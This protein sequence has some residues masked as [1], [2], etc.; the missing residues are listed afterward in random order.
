MAGGVGSMD[1]AATPKLAPSFHSQLPVV[2]ST[3]P[4]PWASHGHGTTDATRLRTLLDQFANATGLQI[5][6]SYN[7]STAVP[8]HMDE[9]TVA[10]CIST[11]GCRREGFPQRYLGLQ[12]EAPFVY[13][14]PQNRQS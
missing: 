6:Y 14:C 10:Q 13:L 2:H 3:P 9:E 11:L 4:C 12:Q 8:I 7:K 1:V 5:N